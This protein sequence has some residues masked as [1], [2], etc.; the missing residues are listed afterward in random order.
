MKKKFQLENLGCP[1]CAAKMEDAI[2]KLPGV[3]KASVSFF[4][5]KM[6]VQAEEDQMDAIIDQAEKIVHK[7]EPDTN[8]KAL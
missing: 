8:L 6:V 3:E 4:T 2:S 5:Q 7:L 1:V